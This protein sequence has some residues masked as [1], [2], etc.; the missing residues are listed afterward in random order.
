MLKIY[1]LSHQGA[2]LQKKH[3]MAR[4]SKIDIKTGQVR[5][6]LPSTMSLC[7]NTGRMQFKDWVT[8]TKKKRK[9]CQQPN[10]PGNHVTLLKA[11][12]FTL[13]FPGASDSKQ[14]A[15]NV[16]DLG[17]IPGSGRSSGE[18]N[19]YP[20]RYSSLENPMDRGAWW[21]TVHGVTKSQTWLSN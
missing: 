14:S 2:L 16:G 13:S 15:C 9:L 3:V 21:A 12:V 20:L 5:H 1:H 17:L 11:K 8:K 19:G 7:W 4:N 10:S 6:K 18:G